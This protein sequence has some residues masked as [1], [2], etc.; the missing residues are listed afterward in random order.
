MTE[1]HPVP[2]PEEPGPSAAESRAIELMGIATGWILVA[3][4]AGLVVIALIAIARWV[5]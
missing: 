1:L 5:L 2:D 3:G 4:L